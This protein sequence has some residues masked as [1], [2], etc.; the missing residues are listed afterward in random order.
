MARTDAEFAEFANGAFYRL[1]RAA[2]LMTGNE[3]QA[4][5]AAQSALVKTYASWRRVKRQDPYAYSRQIM[6]NH[7]KDQWRRPIREDPQGFE[8]LPE[9]AAVNDFADDVTA[10]RWVIAAL[11]KLADRERAVVVLRHYLDLSEK[12]VAAELGIAIGTVKS[13]NYRALAKLRVTMSTTE[14]T[15]SGVLQ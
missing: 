9:P 5:D 15:T 12:E 8:S 14:T 2:L 3:Q 1:R 7:L 10:R 13:L 6:V 4:E 11:A